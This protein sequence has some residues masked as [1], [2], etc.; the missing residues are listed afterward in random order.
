MELCCI[1][2]IFAPRPQAKQQVKR[3]ATMVAR[4][5]HTSQSTHSVHSAPSSRGEGTK[6]EAKSPKLI[7]AR[8]LAT[9]PSWPGIAVEGM[10]PVMG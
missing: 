6:R 10:V 5:T 1:D 4:P 2:C 7:T 3:A 8:P 9:G